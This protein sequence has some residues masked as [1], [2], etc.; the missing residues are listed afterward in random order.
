[1]LPS[2]CIREA[3]NLRELL[4]VNFFLFMYFAHFLIGYFIVF[5]SSFYFVVILM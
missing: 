1:M 3:F 5:S 2:L 4:L